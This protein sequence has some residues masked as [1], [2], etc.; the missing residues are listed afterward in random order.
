M[1]LESHKEY[2]DGRIRSILALMIKNIKVGGK[3]V[4]IRAPEEKV[5][6]N[7]LLLSPVDD[8][9]DPTK[10]IDANRNR[11]VDSCFT[12]HYEDGKVLYISEVVLENMSPNFCNISIPASAKNNVSNMIIKVWVKQQQEWIVFIEWKLNLTQLICLGSSENFDDSDVFSDNAIVLKL[13]ERYYTRKSYLVSEIKT[14]ASRTV[15]TAPIASYSFDSIRSIN[16]LDKSLKELSG[17]KLLISRNIDKLIDRKDNMDYQMLENEIS[18]LNLRNTQLS[19]Y[20]NQQKSA[21]DSTMSSIMNLKTKINDITQLEEE[22]IPNYKTNYESE[23]EFI[24]N[25]TPSYDESLETIYES[26]KTHF[27]SFGKVLNE[28]ME[29]SRCEQG[30]SLYSMTIMGLEFPSSIKELLSI[31][32]DDSNHLT[33]NYEIPQSQELDILQI[34]SGISYIIQLI[35]VLQEISNLQT[36]YKIEFNGNSSMISDFHGNKFPLFYNPKQT[37]KVN[38]TL[39]NQE[40]ET[41]ISLLNKNLLL[42]LYQINALYKTYDPGSSGLMNHIPI[43]CLDNFLWNMEYLLLFLTAP[44]VKTK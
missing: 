12:L 44:A 32:Y 35:V 2:N 33:N 17:S 1:Q 41:G 4:D 28:I 42:V 3:L 43:D 40:F 13:N 38:N 14:E 31:L 25:Q 10:L 22:V 23:I 16:N 24:K 21:N 29:I 26:S 20:I 8:Y 5:R 30:L 11:L 39:T 36:Y 37:K 6:R 19:K 34:N 7:T 9:N 15:N 18:R 27:R